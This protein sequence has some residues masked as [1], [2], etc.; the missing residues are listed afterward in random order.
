MSAAAVAR[1]HKAN[2]EIANADIVELLSGS[3]ENEIERQTFVD[4]DGGML[5]PIAGGLRIAAHRKEAIADD[6]GGEPMA[7]AHHRRQHK[8]AV[9]AGVERLDRLEGGEEAL[10][11]AFAAG[12]DDV[13]VLVDARAHGTAR[14]RHAGTRG[15]QVSCR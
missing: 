9:E 10:V 4:V 12:G 13:L 2:A 11:L 8:P 6:A 14:G 3:L 15:P 5:E 1:R 7:L